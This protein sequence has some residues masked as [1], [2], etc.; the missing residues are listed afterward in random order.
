[1]NADRWI[2]DDG[3][4]VVAT[5]DV[6]ADAMVLRYVLDTPAVAGSR[7]AELLRAAVKQGFLARAL[8]AVDR[9]T[10]HPDFDAIDATATIRGLMA[11]APDTVV[12]AHE[13]LL[14]GRFLPDRG[15]VELLAEYPALHAAVMDNR[16]CDAAVSHIADTLARRRRHG[17]DDDKS[18]VA[19]ATDVVRPLVEASLRNPHPSNMLLRR[20]FALLPE[21]YQAQV[22]QRVADEPTLSQTHY[23]LVAWLHAGL[24]VEQIADA[25]D[26]WFTYNAHRNLKASFIIRAWLEAGGQRER[27]DQSVLAWI[28]AFGQTQSAQFVY[29]AWLDSGGERERIDDSVLD[30]IK[31]FGQLRSAQFV[32]QSWLDY[33]GQRERIDD[34]V[35]DW[36]GVF[37]QTQDAQFVYRAWLEAGGERERIDESV[38]AWLKTFGQSPEANFV[39]RAWLAAGGRHERI[40]DA[41][42]AWIET[43]GQA[44][45][46]R[47]VYH[48]WLN[49]GGPREPIDAAVLA[50]LEIHGATDEAKYIYDAWLSAGGD[51]NRIA[52][53]CL[54]WFDAHA[55]TLE[56]SFVL[57][58]IVRQ[59]SLPADV[60]HAAIRWCGVFAGNEDAIWRITPLIMKCAAS[61]TRGEA[62]AAVRTLLRCLLFLD[63]NRLSVHDTNQDDAG[64]DSLRLSFFVL[65]ALGLSLGVLGLDEVDREQ[66]KLAHTNLLK[67]SEIYQAS[68]MVGEPFVYP[69]LIHHVALLIE[70]GLVQL[71]RDRAGLMRFADWMRSWPKDA[72]GDLKLALTRLRGVA[73][74]EL[75][76]GIPA[77]EPAAEDQ[78][79]T[80]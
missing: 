79:L 11:H 26:G 72:S 4:H 22:L 59:D 50:W 31:L 19:W 68:H 2:E 47:F 45:F 77:P 28:E 1:M 8:L 5:H 48:G 66:M 41:I 39:Y 33:G 24:P 53:L 42:L 37:G 35:L 54:A 30:W 44:G 3:N 65:N 49:A 6:L 20:A 43:F 74:S 75:W 25:V 69:S 56:A 80:G 34:S 51:F 17:S 70:E 46:A 38:V 40:K 71:D 18:V 15:K 64:E 29:R 62:V 61:E 52:P 27:I 67:N 13:R 12:A 9:L 32:Y 76:D 55:T 36:I 10:G 60:L 63:M 14:R 57:K 21:T 7:L 23:L 58:Y 78:R 73:P 16:D